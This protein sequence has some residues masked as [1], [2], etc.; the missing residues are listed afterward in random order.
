MSV[1][2][3][4]YICSYSMTR[5]LKCF[6]AYELVKVQLYFTGIYFDCGRLNLKCLGLIDLVVFDKV[7]YRLK[8][9]WTK[10][11][12]NLQEKMECLSASTFHRRN[13]MFFNK[14]AYVQ[15]SAE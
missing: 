9:K 15:I 10:T 2:D 14:F 5:V 7:L 3:F 11:G 4:P 6:R 12:N 13:M 1:F 8:V